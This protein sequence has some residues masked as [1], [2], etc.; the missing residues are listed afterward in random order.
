MQYRPPVHR[1]DGT[2]GARSYCRCV[3]TGRLSR[4]GVVPILLDGVDSFAS[5]WNQ[6]QEWFYVEGEEPEP[7]QVLI[8]LTSSIADRFAEGDGASVRPVF[9]NLERA[10]PAADARARAMLLFEFIEDLQNTFSHD[11]DHS[12]ADAC[13]SLLGPLG[14]E[15]WAAVDR[16]W[17]G[18]PA[19]SR[20]IQSDDWPA[21]SR[22]A[23]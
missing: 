1:P 10:L 21:S 7:G 5:E 11:P 22:A 8:A 13:I 3:S 4:A 14:R 6:W 23:P 19:H 17:L 16:F 2:F 18:Q 15:A 9:A 12:R 20:F